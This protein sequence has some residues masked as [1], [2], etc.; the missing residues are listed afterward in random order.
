MFFFSKK[1]P[2]EQEAAR[3][4]KLRR[5]E[6]DR[7]FLGCMLHPM[8]EILLGDVSIIRFDPANEKMTITCERR[9]AEIPYAALRGF[10][11]SNEHEIVRGESAITEE[12]L[13]RLL[14]AGADQI[15]GDLGKMEE[16]RTRWFI[17]IDYEEEGEMKTVTSFLYNA[18]GPYMSRSKLLGAAQCEEIVQDILMR[19]REALPEA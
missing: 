17:R 5:T 12:E 4:E 3:I 14:L 1:T 6:K 16:K 9:K 11:V 10:T 15:F 2:E 8:G 13:N 7:G 18:R 19:Y